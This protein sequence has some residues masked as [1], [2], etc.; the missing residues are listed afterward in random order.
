MKTGI[1]FFITFFCLTANAEIYKSV[2]KNGVVTFSD[3]P[4]PTSEVAKL[5]E[6][7]I[8]TKAVPKT[9]IKAT[10][11]ATNAVD[12][13]KHVDYTDFTISSQKNEDTVWNADSLPVSVNITPALQEGDTVQFL[14][15]GSAVVPAVASTS[16]SIPKVINEQ[17]VLVRGT[18]TISAN[19]LNASGEVLKTTPSITVFLHYTSVNQPH[20]PNN[21]RKP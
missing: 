10:T 17:A 5:G 8:V 9:I 6:V 14:L 7:N 18:H 16:T 20:P 1:I 21:G 15:N 11:D 3:Q 19:V 13:T 2:D 4:T 12:P